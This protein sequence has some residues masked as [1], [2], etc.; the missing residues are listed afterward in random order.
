MS[1]QIT[2]NMSKE[3]EASLLS[4]FGSIVL[5][6]STP[7]PEVAAPKVSKKRVKVQ[8]VH[9]T[10]VNTYMRL[11][12]GKSQTFPPDLARSAYRSAYLWNAKYGRYQKAKLSYRSAPDGS[13]TVYKE[14][15][16]YV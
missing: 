16:E 12:I 15:H 2:I 10:W 7:T 9:G 1:I 13:V 8:L 4:M 3:L 14:V 5:K 6:S 11:A